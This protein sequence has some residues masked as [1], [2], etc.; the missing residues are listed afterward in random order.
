MKRSSR[1]LRGNLVGLV[2]GNQM[3][4]AK[5]GSRCGLEAAITPAAIEI[6]PVNMRSC[7]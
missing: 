7:R 5:A 3:G 1:I 2:L 6:E 4:I